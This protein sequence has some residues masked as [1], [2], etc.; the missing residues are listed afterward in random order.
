MCDSNH[1]RLHLQRGSLRICADYALSAHCLNG[2][3]FSLHVCR[4]W[5]AG[6]CSTPSCPLPHDMRSLHNLA[7][8]S[9]AGVIDCPRAT[10]LA[11]RSGRHLPAALHLLHARAVHAS[12]VS[13]TAHVQGLAALRPLL[14]PLSALA[15]LHYARAQSAPRLRDGYPAGHGTRQHVSAAHS[16]MLAN[17]I[18]ADGTYVK[19]SSCSCFGA[20]SMAMFQA[21]APQKFGRP[22]LLHAFDDELD[23][24]E[25]DD[26]NDLDSVLSQHSN[27]QHSSWRL[28]DAY[29]DARPSSS[30]ALNGMVEVFNQRP[31]QQKARA[32]YDRQSSPSSS[33][34]AFQRDYPAETQ[35][36]STS[37]TRT[38]S[39]PQ[40][41]ASSTS[42][43]RWIPPTM[44]A[45]AAAA[46]SI[47]ADG[48]CP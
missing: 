12:D 17:V 32:Q 38:S 42:N 33:S 40:A 45:P 34:S 19:L 16:A 14:L 5:L 25:D 20:D 15:Q 43:G 41:S 37:T 11:L 28:L 22:A 26:T 39:R 18:C 7:A 4:A 30:Q 36:T 13:Q 2:Q 31:N 48:A 9:Y 1:Q 24:D 23:A 47:T 10:E 29:Q 21:P 3:C 44:P 35:M 8:L 6:N 27:T 46:A